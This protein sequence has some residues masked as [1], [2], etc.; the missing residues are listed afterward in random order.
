MINIEPPVGDIWRNMGGVSGF[1]PTF[2]TTNRSKRS[3][4]LDLKKTDGL[5]ILKALVVDAA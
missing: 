4:V 3:V 5:E 2:T 1:S